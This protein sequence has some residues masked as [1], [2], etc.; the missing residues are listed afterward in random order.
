LLRVIQLTGAAGVLVEDVVDVFEGLFE[1]VGWWQREGM[2]ICEGEFRPIDLSG[3]CLFIP[4][5]DDKL[6]NGYSRGNLE[7]QR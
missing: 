6:G 4:D 2:G 7:V 3:S 1:H 5:I